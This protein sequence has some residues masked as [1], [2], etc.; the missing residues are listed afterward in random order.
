MSEQVVSPPQRW[1][2]TRPG[3]EF[4]S[5]LREDDV[6]FLIDTGFEEIWV[7]TDPS[8]SDWVATLV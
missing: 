8:E 6:Y 4:F 5:T 7:S 3:E 1:R 2:V